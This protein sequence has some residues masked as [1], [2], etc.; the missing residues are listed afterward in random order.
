MERKTIASTLLLLPVAL[1]SLVVRA[2]RLPGDALTSQSVEAWASLGPGTQKT[3]ERKEPIGKREI[4][5]GTEVVRDLGPTG[6]YFLAPPAGKILKMRVVYRDGR[7]GLI[8]PTRS[9][10]LILVRLEPGL[11][12]IDI[13]VAPAERASRPLRLTRTLVW[14]GT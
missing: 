10:E 14:T 4:Q 13:E 1:F 11:N 5:D 3:A 8:E 7:S 2:E 6:Y 12:R 9:R